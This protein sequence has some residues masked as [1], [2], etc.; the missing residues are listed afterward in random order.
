MDLNCDENGWILEDNDAFIKRIAKPV[1]YEQAPEKDVIVV[2]C[3]R[4]GDGYL[5][6]VRYFPNGGHDQI[7]E[8]ILDLFGLGCC[9][10]KWINEFKKEISDKYHKEFLEAF[11]LVYGSFVGN[12]P[13]L[14]KGENYCHLYSGS[15]RCSIAPYSNP[16]FFQ[17]WSRGESLGF[18][19]M[20]VSVIDSIAKIKDEL[21]SYEKK[22]I[23]RVVPSQAARGERLEMD[24]TKTFFLLCKERDYYLI[25]FMRSH[26]ITVRGWINHLSTV[27]GLEFAVVASSSCQIPKLTHATRFLTHKSGGT[28]ITIY[29]YNEHTVNCFY[30]SRN[31]AK[32][33]GTYKGLRWLSYRNTFLTRLGEILEGKHSMMGKVIEYHG[34][35]IMVLSTNNDINEPDWGFEIHDR[36]EAGLELR[37]LIVAYHSDHVFSKKEMI[38][39]YKEGQMCCYVTD[40]FAAMLEN[41]RKQYEIVRAS[42]LNNGN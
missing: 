21:V 40:E 3:A 32:N 29:Y 31:E 2:W 19:K 22:G 16:P 15:V 39:D 38:P 20:T 28:I 12:T 27:R 34:Y 24:G 14:I 9:P 13:K 6:E 8:G 41:M 25:L 35:S 26:G 10:G 33:M 4:C 11:N 5:I 1:N 17:Q 23:E 18:Y 42:N 30:A 7:K 36:E 37:S